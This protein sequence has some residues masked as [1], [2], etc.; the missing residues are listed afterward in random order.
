MTNTE[1]EAADPQI[2]QTYAEGTV[3]TSGTPQGAGQ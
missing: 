3:T 2:A 1:H